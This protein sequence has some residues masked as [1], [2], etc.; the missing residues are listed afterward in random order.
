VRVVRDQQEAWAFVR[1]RG[2]SL[3]GPAL[4]PSVAAHIRQVFGAD[5]SAREVVERILLDVREQGDAALR[6]YS[7]ALDGV[8]VD[9]L[10]VTPGELDA[11]RDRVPA[12]LVRAMRVAVARILAYHH[13]Q[14]EA[15]PH[16]FEAD[17]VG[18]IVQPLERVGIYIPGGAASYPSTVLMTA[19]PARVAGVSEVVIC[20]P[21]RVGGVPPVVLVA[22][23]LVEVDRVFQVGGAAAI[24]AM[25]WGTETL[26]RVDKV[27]GPGNIFVQLAKKAVFG[28][29]G[30]DGIQGPTETVVL[31][32]DSAS[33]ALCAADLLA[34]AEHDPM[35]SPVLITTSLKL[36]GAVAQEVDRQ[37]GILERQD[38]ARQAV[39]RQGAI[40]LAGSMEQAMDMANAYAPE[41]LCLM[42]RDPNAWGGR[43]R[44]AGGIFI[45]ETSPEA[46]GDYVAGPSHVMPTGGT[47]RFSSALG[48]YDFL[49][50]TSLVSVDSKTFRE[51][52]PAA[53]LI[54]RAEALTGH[55]R[56][57]EARLEGD[58]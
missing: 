55:A 48:V 1:R 30:V 38:I 9:K 7:L 12:D 35:A 14:R 37:L 46:L 44:H 52:G 54:A 53:A 58:R 8:A 40:L 4:P 50:V 19:I 31:A 11:A 13:R 16:S 23:E 15:G 36:A 2:R 27:C 21:P 29:V 41:H 34:Q 18:Q 22:A 5:L 26:P 25:A 57:L 10:E 49:K 20:T 6:H 17:G 24:A 43:V 32:D 56:A 28:E 42:V 39:D 45:G 51:T 47:A 33:P 3:S